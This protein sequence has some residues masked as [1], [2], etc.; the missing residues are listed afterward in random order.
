MINSDENA[1]VNPPEE[2][3]AV[4]EDAAVN[5]SHQLEP[6]APK[7]ELLREQSKPPRT[8]IPMGS[9]SSPAKK[10]DAGER[11]ND[12]EQLASLFAPDVASQYQKQWVVL[13]QRF[14]DD[15]RRAVREGDELVRQVMQN[16]AENFSNERTALEGR[17]AESEQASTEMLR[18]ALRR[19]RSFFERLLSV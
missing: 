11:R 18:I 16:L 7:K 6:L 10:D 8:A 5:A 17:L 4:T 3:N 13:Q 15:P 1:T 14:V 2:R 19:Y 12:R 9:D